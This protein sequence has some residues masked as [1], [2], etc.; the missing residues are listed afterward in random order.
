MDN[1][2]IGYSPASLENT[3][4]KSEMAWLIA[5]TFIENFADP[6]NMVNQIRLFDMV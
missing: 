4:A 1:R 3:A 6:Y 5:G 2:V